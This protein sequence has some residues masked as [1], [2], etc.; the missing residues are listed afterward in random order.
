M[1]NIQ[2][3]SEDNDS[4]IDVVNIRTK[5]TII[6]DATIDN[7]PELREIGNCWYHVKVLK[8]NG[9]GRVDKVS[10]AFNEENSFFLDERETFLEM[11]GRSFINNKRI[12]T[13]IGHNIDTYRGWYDFSEIRIRDYCGN[14]IKAITTPHMYI[15]DPY[16]YGKLA[17]FK[18]REDGIATSLVYFDMQGKEHRIT[19]NIEHFHYSNLSACFV[20]KTELYFSNYKSEK[21]SCTIN[22]NESTIK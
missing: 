11:G 6:T 7:E 2:V 20:S 13:V 1:C 16:N 17:A 18:I 9:K 14:V 19:F 22:I 3:K 15:S 12:I 21:R 10:M 5:E 8:L 4:L